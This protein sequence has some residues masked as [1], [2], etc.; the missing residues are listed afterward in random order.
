MRILFIK[1][2]GKY[3]DLLIQLVERDIKTRYRGQDSGWHG[4]H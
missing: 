2:L 4:Q 1:E 3:K